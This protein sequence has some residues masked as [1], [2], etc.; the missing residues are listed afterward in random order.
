MYLGINYKQLK[1]SIELKYKHITQIN[2]STGAQTYEDLNTIDYDNDNELEDTKDEDIDEDD[3][4]GWDENLIESDPQTTQ[5]DQ[6][7]NVK[8]SHSHSR[9]VVN[10]NLLRKIMI[11]IKKMIKVDTNECEEDEYYILSNK[12]KNKKKFV[13]I[14]INIDN[15]KLHRVLIK[16]ST[17]NFPYNYDPAKKNWRTPSLLLQYQALK[18][19]QELFKVYPQ[20]HIDG[21]ENI[22]ISKPSYNARGVGIYIINSLKDVISA[23]RKAQSHRIMQKYIERP[24]LLKYDIPNPTEN[25]KKYEK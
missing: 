5:S 22:W 1:K 8:S 16:Y 23:G 20:Y 7:R 25:G 3:E 15:N 9:V 2:M 12:K 18:L 24:F 21:K 6:T 4:F 14:K 19:H 11:L 17:I 13:P 10:C